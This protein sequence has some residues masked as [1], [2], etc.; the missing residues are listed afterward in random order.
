MKVVI[1]LI[2]LLM[3]FILWCMCKMSSMIS[4]EEDSNLKK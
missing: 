1:I 4:K 3:T 2:I